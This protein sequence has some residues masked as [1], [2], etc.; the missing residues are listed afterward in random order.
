[1]RVI[2]TASVS[3]SRSEGPVSIVTVSFNTVE[4]TAL[5]L[6]SLYRV[7]DDDVDVLVVENGSSDGSAELL[8]EAADAGLCGLLTNDENIHHG[9]ALNQAMRALVARE[10][11]PRRVWILDSDVVISRGDALGGALDVAARHDAAI[12]GERHWDQWHEVH[13]FELY[14]LLI[15]PAQVWH[16]EGPEFRD[17]GDPSF[18]LLEASHR[19]G[20]VAEDFP[21][22]ADGYVIHRGRA[23]LAGVVASDDRSHP[24]YEWALTHHEPHFGLVAGARERYESLQA[25]FRSEVRDLSGA[26]LIAACQT[27]LS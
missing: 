6:W 27:P 26:S 12:V 11:P 20:Q 7:L 16:P 5:L 15:D 24:L 17:D 18:D 25:R 1:V 19:A 22:A 4:L 10:T 21:F 14:S 23:S 3:D 9:P 8:A 13:R 2:E